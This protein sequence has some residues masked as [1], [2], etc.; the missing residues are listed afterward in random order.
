MGHRRL[1]QDLCDARS[2]LAEAREFF[3]VL[4]DAATASDKKE[5]RGSYDPTALIRVS[6]L[7]PEGE[8]TKNGRGHRKVRPTTSHLFTD[9]VVYT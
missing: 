8:K 1:G 9:P 3:I 2:R 5:G 6:S 4:I 7:I